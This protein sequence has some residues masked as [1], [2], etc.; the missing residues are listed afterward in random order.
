MKLVFDENVGKGVPAA[1][2]G[3]GVP[4][5]A[6]PGR[7]PSRNPRIARGTADEVWIPAVGRDG[8][9]VFSCDTGIL[10]A[11]AQRTLLVRHLV[12]AVFLTTGQ[13]KSFEV[14]RLVLRKWDWLQSIDRYEARPFAFLVTMSGRVRKD[15]R[16]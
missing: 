9:L 14:L 5:V 2:R 4:T 11:E 15:G 10:E 3:V 8:Y 13:E 12:G 1:L 6:Y 7:Y 16:V